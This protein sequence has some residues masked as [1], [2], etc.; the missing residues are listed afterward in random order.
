MGFNITEL[1][2]SNV[3]AILAA[4][5]ALCPD[6][7]TTSQRGLLAPDAEAIQAGFI[8]IATSANKGLMSK[9]FA[10]LLALLQDAET[11]S[12]STASAVRLRRSPRA[13][14]SHRSLSLPVSLSKGT[15][16]IR[17]T[18]SLKVSAIQPGNS[19]S[20]MPHG[21]TGISVPRGFFIL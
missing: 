19:F 18:Q 20:T 10:E 9:A 7:V 5:Q 16:F 8:K 17:R 11:A 3:A 13:A 4:L 21:C 12:G 1:T 2:G 14:I 6:L 15:L